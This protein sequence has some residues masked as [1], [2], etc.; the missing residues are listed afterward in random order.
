[1]H[2]SPVAER[3]PCL[4]DA[5]LQ[6]HVTV[7]YVILC[8]VLNLTSGGLPCQRSSSEVIYINS[9]F[10]HDAHVYAYQ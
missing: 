3:I 2:G 5:S 9:M 4:K 6:H 7:L 10:G 1:M 8:Y